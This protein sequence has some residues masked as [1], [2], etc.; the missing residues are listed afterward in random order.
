MLT[1]GLTVQSV[2]IGLSGAVTV[3]ARTKASHPTAFE[4]VWL[5]VVGMQVEVYEHRKAWKGVPCF[6]GYLPL[7]TGAKLV[8][9]ARAK[10]LREGMFTGEVEWRDGQKSVRWR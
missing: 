5:G 3:H 2:R 7:E 4:F 6:V 9:M 8:T 1:E 10:L